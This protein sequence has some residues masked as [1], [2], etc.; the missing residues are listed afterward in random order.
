[1]SHFFVT[2]FF[3][4]GKSSYTYVNMSSENMLVQVFKCISVSNRTLQTFLRIFFNL[5]AILSIQ[6]AIS[7]KMRE[8]RDNPR[9]NLLDYSI[10]KYGAELVG[11]IRRLSRI[12]LLF[13]PLPLFWTLYDQKSSRWTIQVTCLCSFW[14]EC[15]AILSATVFYSVSYS[16]FSPF[17]GITNEW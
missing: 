4:C 11:D 1:M 10:D 15:H 5:S 16:F 14:F 9:K 13:L 17:A 3:L 6:N 8:K 7:T 12:L 2:V